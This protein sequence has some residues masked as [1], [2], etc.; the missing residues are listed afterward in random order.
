MVVFSGSNR[1]VTTVALI[2]LM[3][4]SLIAFLGVR[5]ASASTV[6]FSEN[7]NSLANGSEPASWHYDSGYSV[8]NGTYAS[9]GSSG[10]SLAYY[11]GATF[12]N[13]TYQDVATGVPH[14]GQTP[15]VLAVAFRM[16]N[17]TNGYWFWA[18]IDKL[19]IVKWVDGQPN[20][21]IVNPPYNSKNIG[22]INPTGTFNMT[23]VANGNQLTAIWN[24]QYTITVDDSTWKSG[25]IGVGTYHCNAEF[26]DLQVTSLGQ[27]V[28]SFELSTLMNTY[29]NRP[30]LQRAFPEASYGDY[31]NLVTW[32]YGVVSQQWVDGSYNT[33][34]PYAYW[35]NLMNTYNNRPDLQVAYPDAYTSTTS[36]QGL[37]NWAAGVVTKQW[38]DGSYGALNSTAYWYE[39]MGTYNGRSDL[40]SAFPNAYSNTITTD[41]QKLLTWAGGVVSQKWVDGSYS[42]LSHF[43]YWYDLFMTYN[44]RSDLQAS[45]PG[46]YTNMS[47]YKSLV[48]WAGGV[49]AQQWVDGSYSQLNTYGYWYDLMMV[50]NTRTDLQNVFPGAYVLHSQYQSLINWANGVVTHA[51]PDGAITYLNYYAAYYESHHT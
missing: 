36:Y 26:N 21:L 3:S 51:W 49:V 5:P 4:L 1:R 35:Y 14:C 30:D 46:A 38:S 6:L 16:Q 34:A 50:Y 17:E 40:Q 22:S 24:S 47:E 13:F 29:A 15:P 11:T 43:G 7:F 42:T 8:Q 28:P 33:L 44:Q 37:I 10:Y 20:Y 48:N 45:F 31:A 39:L 25:Y 32:A 23:I 27:H 19:Q 18:D 12:S 2:A 9:V 41:Y